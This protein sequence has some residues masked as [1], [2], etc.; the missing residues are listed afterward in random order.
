MMTF[1]EKQ[2]L[3]QYTTRQ[4]YKQRAPGGFF[5]SRKTMQ[6]WG[7]ALKP[8][9]RICDDG[10][11]LFITSDNADPRGIN[12]EYNLRAMSLSGNCT[13]LSAS[14]LYAEA[15]EELIRVYNEMHE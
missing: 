3:S 11:V 4:I 14:W 9:R 5:F 1:D 7:S 10:T 8:A 13:K 12:K 2:V 15:K 6:F